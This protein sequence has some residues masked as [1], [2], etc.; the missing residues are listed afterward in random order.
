MHAMTAAAQTLAT[1]RA[2]RRPFVLV[3]TR[4]PLEFE[5]GHLPEATSTSTPQR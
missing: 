2:A 4:P 1:W 5:I 3:D